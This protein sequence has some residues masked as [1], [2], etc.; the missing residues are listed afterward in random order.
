MFR[1]GLGRRNASATALGFFMAL[2]ATVGAGCGHPEDATKGQPTASSSSSSSPLELEHEPGSLIVRFKEEAGLSAA[3]TNALARIRGSFEDRDGDGRYDR[4]S[5]LDRGGLLMKVDLEPS[6]SVKEALAELRDDPA[7]EYAEPNY[8]YRASAIPNDPRFPQQYGLHNLGGYLGGAPDADIDAPEAWEVSTG[9]A[10]VVVGVLDTGIDYRHVDL[11]DNMWVN[12]GELPGNG[13]DDDGNGVVDDV[14]GYNAIEDSGDP[15]DDND[16]GTLCAG[17]IGATGDN[18]VGVVGVSWKVSLMAL[19]FLGP[20]GAGTTADAIAA[21]DYALARKRAGVNLRVLSSSWNG[22]YS[23]ALMEAIERAEEADLLMVASAGNLDRD[24]DRAPSYPA[25]FEARNLIA[26]TATDPLDFLLFSANV[27][28]RSVDLG[29]PG[30][31]IVSTVRN[32]DYHWFRGSSPAAAY[33]AGA[34]ALVLSVN[35]TLSTPELKEILLSS[36]DELPSLAGKTLTGKRL[37]VASAI[38]Q[39][40]P[41]VSRFGLGVSPI[42]LSVAQEAQADVAIDVTSVRGYTGDVALT[43][44]S[45]PRLEAGL[46][47]TSPEVAAPG[48]SALQIITTAATQPGTYELTVT[49]QGGGLTLARHVSLRVVPVGA[50]EERHDSSDTPIPFSDGQTITSA[51]RVARD[52]QVRSAMV[53]I[54]LARRFYEDLRVSL[55]S[56]SGTE[57]ALLGVNGVHSF[58]E[59]LTGESSVGEWR[60]RVVET[61]GAVDFPGEL[62]TWTLHLSDQPSRSTFTLSG[63]QEGEWTTQRAYGNATFDVRFHEWFRNRVAISVTSD[64]PMRGA[65]YPIP[66]AMSFSSTGEISVRPTCDDAPGEYHLRVTGTSGSIVRTASIPLTVFPA[67][68]RLVKR[69]SVDSSHRILD[70][71]ETESEVHEPASFPIA[72]LQA[73]VN[74]SHPAIDELTVQLV[75]SSGQTFTLHERSGGGQDELRRSY[76]L[77]QLIGANVHGTWRLRIIDHVAGNVGVLRRWGI[78]AADT[79]LG[80]DPAF[81]VIKRGLS[82][83]LID[84]SSDAESC[85]PGHLTRRRWDFGDGNSST[86]VNPEHTYA[87]AG[88]YQVTLTVTDNDGFSASYSSEVSVSLRP[89]W[90]EAVKRAIAPRPLRAPSGETTAPQ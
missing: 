57:I 13:L 21:L 50:I 71:G 15:M 43:V 53:E 42:R 4:F 37:N 48:A 90:I 12:P 64:P 63:G 28:F 89:T 33:V 7:V 18:G 36:G 77:P 88:T 84:V 70:A 3:R 49:G 22:A 67:G 1:E 23:L 9:S 62:Q 25:S 46:I 75:S 39:A 16:H 35:E 32:N 19:K 74:I 44:T 58:P 14:H 38:S 17:I 80:P 52:F 66:P 27:G 30:E 65:L 69:G 51:I 61:A 26:V 45:T 11:R 81:R 8:L 29:A 40:G 20:D 79:R 6:V 56:P 59:E 5:N 73:F 82:V 87:A 34:A 47:L 2:A 76:E 10:A 72:K 24:L 54:S 55:I 41:P 85:S 68:S 83:S 86:E 78:F 31:G 60:L